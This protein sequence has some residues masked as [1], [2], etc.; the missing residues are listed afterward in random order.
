MIDRPAAKQRLPQGQGTSG[1][2]LRL[3]PGLAM[4]LVGPHR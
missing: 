1:S 4:Q 3:V 2:A